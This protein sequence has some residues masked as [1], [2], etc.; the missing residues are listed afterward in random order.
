M[1]ATRSATRAG[2]FVERRG[3]VDAVAEADVLGALAG[4]SQKYLWCGGMGVFLQKMML[5]LPHMIEAD[6]V[7]DLNLLQRFMENAM[8]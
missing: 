7:C 2:W 5:H 3:Q 6:A 4:S 8:L 1:S